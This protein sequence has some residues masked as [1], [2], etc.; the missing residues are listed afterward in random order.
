MVG[1]YVA[2]LRVILNDSIDSSDQL[3]VPVVVRRDGSYGAVEVERISR[4]AGS[5]AGRTHGVGFACREVIVRD[6]HMR[7][8]EL[9]GGFNDGGGEAGHDMKLDVTVEEPDP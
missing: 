7:G 9:L 5:V 6:R 4:I 8:R 1:G 2:L 3:H